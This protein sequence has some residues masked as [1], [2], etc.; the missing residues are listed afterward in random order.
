MKKN[1]VEQVF[2]DWL[3]S[4]KKGR[5]A[6][7]WHP[8]HHWTLRAVWEYSGTSV[9]DVV[10]R[11][12]LYQAGA[13]KQAIAGFPCHWAYV[14]G[15]SCLSCTLCVLASGGDINNGA[16]HNPWTWA[17]LALMEIIGGWGFQQNRW[18][19]S[20]HQEVLKMSFRQRD[21]LL[22]ILYELGLVERWNCTY[23]LNLLCHCPGE[24]SLFWHNEAF[25]GI[26]AAI[27]QYWQSATEV[28]ET[29]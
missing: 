13:I 21:R 25:L 10:R 19:S 22:K 24:F 2:Q 9:A 4:G 16:K 20:L 3:N 6:L 11:I 8:I 14:A 29:V 5:F 23:T 18:L 17:E 27:A 1:W 15:N 12:V 28:A 26:A 7:T